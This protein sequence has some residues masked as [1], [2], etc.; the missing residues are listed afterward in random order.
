[1]AWRGPPE[2][3]EISF[4]LEVG[5]DQFG[6][7]LLVK[8]AN[9]LEV[10]RSGALLRKAGQGVEKRF[11][12]MDVAHRAL[13]IVHTFEMRF[14]IIGQQGMDDFDHVPELFEGQPQPVDG[15]WLGRIQ[16]TVGLGCP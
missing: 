9:R 14:G 16:L 8:T 1:M 15:G 4:V 2:V 13:I 10:E 7:A 6:V 12:V 3:V 11:N 5:R